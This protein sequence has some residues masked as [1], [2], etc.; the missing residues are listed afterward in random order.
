MNYGAY[1]LNE[2]FLSSDE[3][4]RLTALS[5]SKRALST[6]THATGKYASNLWSFIPL[7]KEN[8]SEIPEGVRTSDVEKVISFF[9]T[10]INMA[11][12][13]YLEPGGV[14]H[15]HRDLTGAKLN[16]RIRFHIPLQTNDQVFFNVAGERLIMAPGTLWAL[17]TSYVHSV[18]NDGKEV[19]VH[20][21]I[22]CE[23]N[24]WVKSLL[25]K[26]NF[27]TRIH[28]IYYVLYLGTAVFRSLL[29][30]TWKDPKYLAAQIGMGI[31]FIKWRTKSLLSSKKT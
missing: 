5:L 6:P 8:S 22:E 27:H 11:V 1:I 7:V 12:F 25:V 2:K 16:D 14:L 9:K 20:I 21:V 4:E 17:D 26:P 3:I 18:R 30:N 29:V 31:R 15:P 24:S 28:D 10:D 23:V 13:Y 19:R